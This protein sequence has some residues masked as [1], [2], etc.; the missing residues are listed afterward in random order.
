MEKHNY[1]ISK[2]KIRDFKERLKLLSKEQ[3]YKPE[4]IT[5]PEIMVTKEQLTITAEPMFGWTKDHLLEYYKE[6]IHG[7]ILL[8]SSVYT[9]REDQPDFQYLFDLGVKALAAGMRL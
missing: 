2:D 6:K 4:I 1:I 8:T 9:T 3:N 7:Q 5:F